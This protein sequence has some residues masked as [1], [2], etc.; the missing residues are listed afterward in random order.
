MTE[1]EFVGEVKSWIDQILQLNTELPFVRAKIEQRGA[2]SNKRRDLTLIG[3]DGKPLLTGEVKLPY[4]KDGSSPYRSDVIADAKRKAERAGVKFFF[5][6]NVNEC[7]LW[8]TSTAGAGLQDR[9]YERWIVTTVSR[10]EHLEQQTVQHEL[11]EW[12]VKFLHAVAPIVIGRVT[13]GARSPDLKFV[14]ALESA[15]ALPI[16]HT[17]DELDSRYRKVAFKRD[18]D[19]WMVSLGWQIVDDAE[20]VRD[21]LE[22]AAKFSCYLLVNKLVFHEALLKKYGKKLDPLQAP[23]EVT[24]GD[25]LRQRLQGYFEDARDV[26]GDYETIFGEDPLTIANRLPFYADAGVQSW[27]ALIEQIHEFD[28]S[29]LDYEIVGAI[30]ERLIGPEERHK[31][32]QYYTR[33]EVVDLIN[34]FCIQSA[35]AKVLDPA[36]GGGTFLVRAYARKKSFKANR[37]HRDLLQDIYGIDQSHFAAHLTTMNLATRDLVEDQ[38]YPCIG[39]E[40]FF[41]VMPDTPFMKLPQKLVSKGLGKPSYRDV[42]IPLLD[43]LVANPPYVRQED[44]RKTKQKGKNVKPD[45]GT[46]EFYRQRA[47]ETAGAALSGRSDLHCYFW[48]HASA[49]L[50]NEGVLGFIT[51]SQWLDVEYGFRLQAWLMENFEILAVLESPV[52][53]WFIGA[54]VAT[55][56]TIARKCNN[57]SRRNANIVRFV[58]L[59]QPLAELLEH[60]GTTAGA[61]TA[62]DRLRDEI[63]EVSQNVSHHRYR[64]RLVNQGNLWRQGVELGR[65]MHGAENEEEDADKSYDIG[66]SE[67]KYYGGKWGVYLRAPDLWFELLDRFGNTLIALGQLA[68]IRRGI[69]SGNDDFFFPKDV[70]DDRLNRQLDAKA[71]EMEYGIARKRVASG[72]V[73]LVLA[74]EGHGELHA[75]EAK[76]LEPEV[77]SLMG[78]E[79]PLVTASDCKNQVFLC[80]TSNT[81]MPLAKRYIQWGEKKGWDQ[82]ATCA[83]R[84]TE[85][86]D[87]YDL[88]EHRRAPVLW[89]KEKQY[90]HIAP[91]NPTGLI[92]N[93]RL[94]EVYPRSVD[95]PLLWGGLLNSSWVLLSSFQFGRPMGNEGNWSTMVVDV[96]MML[97]P[98]INLVSKKVR[99]LVSSTFDVLSQ[100]SS[101]QFLSEKRMRQMTYEKQG[102]EMALGTL[103]DECELDMPDRRKLDHAVLELLGVSSHKEREV[104]IDQ[105]YNYLREFFEQTRKKEEQAILNKNTS[106][107]KGAVST[108]DLAL[109]IANS[110]QATEPRWFKTYRDIFR[111]RPNR[112]DYITVEVPMEG[113]ADVK[114]DMLSIGVRF[115]RGKKDVGF[116]DTPS[117]AHAELLALACN[118]KRD[119]EMRSIIRLP[120]AEDETKEFLLT[121]REFL[122]DRDQRLRELIAERVSDEEIQEKVL[123]LLRD[124][125]RRSAALPRPTTGE[126]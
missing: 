33:V 64:A 108:Q 84:V 109:Q 3:H 119:D 15:L 91:A 41:N 116:V 120:I 124:R 22:R 74:G 32:G 8:E 102:R 13:I 60:D 20:G 89:P 105:L 46:K 10:P 48:P 34:S 101:L 19:Q 49:F 58:Q 78:I 93:C 100:R 82:T 24:T 57:A 28:F 36:C 115:R 4:A 126:S 69:T 44:I 47:K 99:Q 59:R 70:S 72:E 117:K 103:S 81:L 43:A 56:V 26:T 125:V 45:P 1:W 96:S 53:P 114:H 88:T 61:M 6:W 23:Q 62:A 79:R 77:H 25:D 104:W 27:R 111:E 83:A 121:Y 31:F 54:R 14:E 80:K 50:K 2:G 71:F 110:L 92:A 52:E 123:A 66:Q 12:L 76:Y 106:K 21:L 17:F 94:Y 63:L 30:F 65:I 35:D 87:W 9:A 39:R 107:R 40:D 11:Y 97:V 75:I 73:K 67:G 68:E 42:K 7:L 38:N 112:N 55:V 16:R 90:R 29:K 18:L 5:T 85:T 51:S 86:R 37:S 113:L 95:D 98:N 118:E 122:S